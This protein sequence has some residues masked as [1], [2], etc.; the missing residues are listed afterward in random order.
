MNRRQ[1]LPVI[2]AGLTLNGAT[3]LRR[4]VRLGYEARRLSFNPDEPEWRAVRPLFGDPTQPRRPGA[5]ERFAADRLG[6]QGRE[7]LFA[8]GPS[9]RQLVR[10]DFDGLELRDSETLLEK[11]EHRIRDVGRGPDGFLRLLIDASDAPMLRLES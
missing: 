2:V 8:G 5:P 10:L 9:G 4:M 7:H 6:A 11:L 3:V 1:G